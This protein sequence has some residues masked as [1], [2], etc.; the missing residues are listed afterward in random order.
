MNPHTPNTL[1]S[2]QDRLRAATGI[3]GDGSSIVQVMG[4]PWQLGLGHWHLRA[5][6][7]DWC[8]RKASHACHWQSGC[9]LDVCVCVCVCVCVLDSVCV[10]VCVSN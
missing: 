6:Q 5:W 9:D 1:E 8:E 4:R 2:A 7:G 10:Y 3:A